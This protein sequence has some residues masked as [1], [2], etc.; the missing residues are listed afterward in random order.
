MEFEQLK[1]KFIDE[2]LGLITS[3]EEALLDNEG[4]LDN[5]DSIKQI[6][7]VM[8]T[9]K[10]V[11]SMY[12]F[13]YIGELAHDLEN[14]FDLIRDHR[15]EFSSPIFDVTLKSVDH[16]RN[17]LQDEKLLNP[18]VRSIHE[19]LLKEIKLVVEHESE[20]SFIGEHYAEST[21]ISAYKETYYIILYPDESLT[22]RSINVLRLFEELAE[23]GEYR[24]VNHTFKEHDPDYSDHHAWGV[25]FVTNAGLE[26]IEE[27]FMFVLDDCKIVKVS[28]ENLFNHS[29]FIEKLDSVKSGM[30]KREA[31]KVQKKIEETIQVINDEAETKQEADSK[32][33][34][35]IIDSDLDSVEI[36]SSD[37]GK[38]K[39][40]NKSLTS[41]IS[42]ESS[43]LDQLMYLVSEL[44]ITKSQL[45]LA[46]REDDKMKLIAITEKIDDLS[47]NF[48][49][50]ALSIRLVSVA[51]MI[52]P[53]KR[54]VRDL[55]KGLGKNIKFITH[56]IDTELD[57]NVIDR[58]AEPVMHILRN[59]IDHGI[60][61]SQTRIANRKP[62]N[63][64][65]EFKSFYSGANVYI[66]IKDDGAGLNAEKIMHKAIEKGLISNDSALSKKDIYDLIFLPGFSTAKQV[67]DVSGRGVGMD[68]VR[69]KIQELR[70]EVDI[71]SEE[72]KGTTITI[73]LHQTLSIIDTLL[74]QVDNSHYLVPVSDIE[75]CDQAY[76]E[77][78]YKNKNRQIELQEDLIPFVSI[79]DVFNHKSDYPRKEK[80]IVI[81]KGDT[82]VAIVADKIIGEH[83][84]VLK[85][86][87]EMFHAQE[88]LSGAS[89]LGDGSLALM[90]DINKIANS[91]IINQN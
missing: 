23:L 33:I 32:P 90:L 89:I 57:K 53:F 40:I 76:H 5:E 3:L 80:I 64:E 11:S 84:A 45:S 12:G 48:R 54:L 35:S 75:F 68:I 28:S 13:D 78:L 18:E 41:R 46:V 44:V 1:Q 27:V 85:P 77:I 29:E 63:G 7:R 16:F 19:S 56:G 60:E 31:G 26:A 83:Q 34:Q 61:D 59:S 4:N 22:F 91:K 73:K 55:S 43:K 20:E 25:Y 86:L 42:I 37:K 15:K 74:L 21:S 10:G 62:A 47:R 36:D 14:I 52:M 58:L 82:R 66:Q 72:G 6:F 65:I 38:I 8:H 71:D 87:G 69:K 30:A 24:I 49:D 79:R 2:A 70:G 81:N 88:Y 9:L 50:N 17:L 51:E 39:E 67:S